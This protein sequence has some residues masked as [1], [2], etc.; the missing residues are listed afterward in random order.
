MTCISQ[1]QFLQLRDV[2]LQKTD[3][4]L[5]SAVNEKISVLGK[6][7]GTLES[8]AKFCVTDIFVGKIKILHFLVA[9]QLQ[10]SVSFR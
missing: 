7:E 1:E 9:L 4:T 6:F 3:R 8:E 5:Y 10:L 2:K